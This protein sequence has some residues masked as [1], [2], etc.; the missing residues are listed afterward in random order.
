MRNFADPPV[1]LVVLKTDIDTFSALVAEAQDGSKKIIV[2]KKK[3]RDVVV[4]KLRRWALCR[5][6]MQR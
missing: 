2:E 6:C 5:V 3:E 1:D 4:R